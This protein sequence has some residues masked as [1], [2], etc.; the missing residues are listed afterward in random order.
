MTEII[1][2]NPILIEYLEKAYNILPH[3]NSNLEDFFQSG[4]WHYVQADLETN[5]FLLKRLEEKRL[6]PSEVNIVDCGV[7]LA[8]ILFDIY[9]Q[10]KDFDNKFTFTGI[11]KH[12]RYVQFLKSELNKY[13]NGELN[14]IHDDIMNQ[15]YSKYNFI[16]FY[17]PFKVSDKA[18]KFYSKVINEAPEGAIIIGLNHFQVLTYGDV[19]LIEIFNK[20][21]PHKI[22]D[23]VV[24]KK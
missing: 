13:W 23:V 9:L 2:P 12:E 4:E 8:T 7:G 18:I 15:D 11:E 10:S 3:L 21:K 5:I 16:Y 19:D 17:Q 22:D 24:F 14:I 6:L 1:E 20:L